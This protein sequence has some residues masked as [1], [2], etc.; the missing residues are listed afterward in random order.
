MNGI[1]IIYSKDLEE[2]EVS[3]MMGLIRSK[4]D[5]LCKAISKFLKKENSPGMRMDVLR[6]LSDNID[7]IPQDSQFAFHLA[8]L[9]G[10]SK[11]D[12]SYFAFIIDYFNH[13]PAI[14]INDFM[15]ILVDSV[16]KNIPLNDIQQYFLQGGSDVTSIFE[17]V[18]HYSLSDS[19]LD[20]DTGET[21]TRSEVFDVD[22]STIEPSETEQKKE[23]TMVSVFGDLLTVMTAGK[24]NEEDT[25]TPIQNKF[26]EFVLRFQS[27]VNDL[28]AF[29]SQVVHE[30][31]TDKEEITRLK[32]LYN[33]QQ[34]MLA[35]QQQKLYV[36][37][38]ENNRLRQQVNDAEK[39]KIHRDTINQKAKELERLTQESASF[40]LDD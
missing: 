38:D 5:Y 33:I 7:D 29:F 28:A 11:M 40:F 32:A 21:A 14:D 20:E 31:E 9:V 26:N 39:L 25:I 1:K 3:N 17:K 16:E 24:A 18:D 19:N 4:N 13:A 30:W 12:T 2:N 6:F 15:I 22:A 34:R 23:D 35:S 10:N 36:K 27:D 8:S 37:R